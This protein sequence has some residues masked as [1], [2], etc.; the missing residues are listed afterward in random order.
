MTARKGM[1][2]ALSATLVTMVLGAGSASAAAPGVLDTSFG[3]GNGMIGLDL[4]TQLN[5]GALQKDGRLVVTGL[6]NGI[7]DPRLLVQRYLSNGSIDP[8]FGAGGTATAPIPADAL[9]AIGEDVFVQADG[10]IIVAARIRSNSGAAGMQVVRYLDNGQLDAGFGSGG[11]VN[12]F[13]GNDFQAAATAVDVKPSGEIVV[14]G[15]SS[16]GNGLV[17][18]A[19]IARLNPAGGLISGPHLF[20]NGEAT[21]RGLATQGDKTIVVGTQ[22][23]GQTILGFI[24]RANADGGKDASFRNGGLLEQNFAR[25]GAAGS[26]LS[27]VGVQG[28]GGLIATGYAFDGGSGDVPGALEVTARYDANG[29]PDGG[30]GSGGVTYIRASRSNSVNTGEPGGG[31]VVIDNGGHIYTAGSWDESG[32][33]ALLANAQTGNG[34]LDGGFGTGGQVVAP[35]ADYAS[36]AY[37]RDAALGADGLYVIGT[38]GTSPQM[39]STTTRG[40][41]A[42]VGAFPVVGCVGTFC[43]GPQPDPCAATP[44]PANCPGGVGETV[45]AAAKLQLLSSSVSKGRLKLRVG[46]TSLASGLTLTA[47]YQ[48]AGTTS[49][50]KLKFPTVAAGKPVVKSYT[51]TLKGK[52]KKSSSGIVTLSS[53]KTTKVRADELRLR[54]ARN[55]ASL[56]RKTASISGGRL[57]VSGTIS[58]RATG[59]ILFRLDYVVGSTVKSFTAKAKISKGKWSLNATLPAEAAKAGGQLAFQYTGNFTKK[60]RGEQ[61]TKAVTP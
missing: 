39:N 42:R 34:A 4:K 46:A 37:G 17:P 36:P 43:G 16:A 58:K 28:D 40:V 3:G 2:V 18:T 55:A 47:K 15:Q 8:S 49:T 1:T 59:S 53:P 35:F 56:T 23:S 29:N 11:V 48:A 19:A 54:V 30:F 60:I 51:L 50:F 32:S 27:D 38:A 31:S 20:N 45:A 12:L 14:G 21:V 44:K 26:G 9:G 52:Q 33:S 41:I 24:A 5:G 6:S 61:Q 22:K 57:K 13:R 10:K 7:D 25:N